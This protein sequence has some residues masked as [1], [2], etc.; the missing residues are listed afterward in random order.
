[1]QKILFD[2]Y[3]FLTTRKFLSLGITFAIVLALGFFA[4]KIS[5]Q[6]NINQLIPSSDK[7]G[8]TTKVLEQVNFADKITIIISAK[9]SGTKEDLTEY[10]T[11]FLDSLDASCKPFVGKVQGKIEEENMQETFDFVYA[12]LPL[13]LDENDY[14]HIQSKLHKDSIART[15]EADYKSII[16]PAGMVSKDFILNDPLGISFIALKKLQQ[17]SVGDKEMHSLA[18]DSQNFGVADGDQRLACQTA[19]ELS[20]GPRAA[21]P[22]E[23]E[24]SERIGA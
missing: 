20:K 5:F 24:G 18:D 4:S 13:F 19:P 3:T 15:I 2:L 6:E 17:L 7:S 8:I 10:A 11:A 9:E 1:M 14:K 12:N 22:H 23:V 21:E 16:S